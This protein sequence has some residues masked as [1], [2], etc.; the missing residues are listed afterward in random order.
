MVILAVAALQVIGKIVGA[1]IAKAAL[2]AVTVAEAVAVQLVVLLVI[3][4]AWAPTAKPLI[5]ISN[6]V[7]K[8][9]EVPEIAGKTPSIV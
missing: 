5:V 3:N 6:V 4:S 2:G 1:V 7:P 8:F 9:G